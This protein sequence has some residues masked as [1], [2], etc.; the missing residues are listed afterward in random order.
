MVRKPATGCSGRE[1][2]DAGPCDVGAPHPVEGF[3]NL[4][5]TSCVMCGSSGSLVN[6]Y[7][8]GCQVWVKRVILLFQF[9]CVCV[10]YVNLCRDSVNLVSLIGDE[11]DLL[12]I[13]VTSQRVG[14]HTLGYMLIS[15]I[16]GIYIFS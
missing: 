5:I 16:L 2:Q 12:V 6:F 9:H 15:T 14:S 1:E 4:L 7:E 13:G 8:L 11:Y 3:V 10:S